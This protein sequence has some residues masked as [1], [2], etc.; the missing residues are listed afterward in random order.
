[1]E[2]LKIENDRLKSQIVIPVKKVD[3]EVDNCR[4]K[5]E[6]EKCLENS[7]VC[8]LINII[9]FSQ[10]VMMS[11]MILLFRQMVNLKTSCST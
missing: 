6:C 2:K 7:K 4:F 11:F 5:E 8:F 10:F 9:Y 1:M 3:R